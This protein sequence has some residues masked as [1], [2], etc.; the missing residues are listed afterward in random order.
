MMWE[1]KREQREWERG[2]MGREREE[3]VRRNKKVET[4]V[5]VIGEENGPK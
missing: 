5:E 4:S 1:S 2:G 3:T